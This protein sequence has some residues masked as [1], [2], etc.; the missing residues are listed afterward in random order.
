M[1]KERKDHLRLID[2]K[3]FKSIRDCELELGDINVLIGSNGAGKS[4]FISVF[5]LLKNILKK[6][7]SRY[8]GQKG[9]PNSLLYNGAKV[10]D[11]IEM[12]FYFGTK[13]ESY[14]FILKLSENNNFVFWNE[15]VGDSGGG[16]SFGGYC[17]SNWDTPPFGKIPLDKILS[18]LESQPLRL[19]H[20]HDT[21]P[22]AKVKQQHSLSNG[23]TL[24]NDAGNLAAFLYN[25]KQHYPQAYSNILYAVQM[26][27]PYFKDFVL[28]PIG[29][30]SEDIL[31]RWQKKGCDEIFFA[32]QLSDGT[33]RFICLATLLLQ[34]M[35]LQPATIII[36]EPELGLHPFAI[37][38]FAEMVKK[39]AVNKQVILATQSVEL[40]DHFD[41]RDVIVVDYGENGSEFRRLD[42][43]K[44]SIWLE[45]DY[46]LG[47]L[48]NKN[49][50]GG[51]P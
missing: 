25:L 24:L 48:W 38:I 1:N 23:D 7:L 12:E 39:A 4:N 34:P 11:T 29:Q 13:R 45:E 3:G 40:L 30:N 28:R 6:N 32:S 27:A 10:T 8:V 26:I 35:E 47:E 20:F 18:I 36:D 2:I 41:A 19:Y 46:T 9:G 50:F 22:N 16:S 49:V 14:S 31:L 51:R 44:L 15:N 37:T 33:L 43:E 21:S 5:E 17:E 42:A